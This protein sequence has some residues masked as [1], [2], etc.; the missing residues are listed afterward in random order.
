M[1]ILK[2]KYYA[3]TCHTCLLVHVTS[4]SELL[5][6]LF[7]ELLVAFTSCSIIVGKIRRID[8]FGRFSVTF[9]KGDNFC[10]FLLIFLYTNPLLKKGSALKGKNL[11]PKGAN[12]FLLEQTPFQKGGKRILTELPSLQK[13]QFP[14][15]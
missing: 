15:T 2:E 9:Y 6:T 14:L 13:H 11:L 1:E 4:I 8:I 7:S 5:V 10:D 12:S 3:Y